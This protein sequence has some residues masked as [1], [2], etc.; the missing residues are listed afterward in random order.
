MYGSLTPG[1]SIHIPKES[2]LYGW[3]LHP[4]LSSMELSQSRLCPQESLPNYD[5][6]PRDPQDHFYRIFKL[7]LR[8]Q[9]LDFLVFL[10][11]LLSGVLESHLGAFYLLNLDF[12]RIWFGVDYC[13]GR[14]AYL[15][16]RNFSLGRTQYVCRHAW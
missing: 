11:R 2:G 16:C 10:S 8:E 6:F 3:R 12:G 4:K 13:I 9:T 7:P 14:M 5:T 1:P 15:G